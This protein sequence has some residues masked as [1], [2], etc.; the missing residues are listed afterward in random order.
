MINLFYHYYK[1]ENVNR[2][3]ELLKCYL[4]NCNLP[5]IDNIYVLQQEDTLLHTKCKLIKINNRPTYIDFFKIINEIA[6]SNDINIICNTDIYFDSTLT[7]LN[8]Y[9]FK[10]HVLC[11]EKY[12]VLPNNTIKF[13]NQYDSQDTWI[14]K[15]KIKEIQE[16]NFT[17]GIPGCDNKLAFLFDKHG[18][19]SINPSL[20][21]KTYHLHNVLY[22]TY[23]K[24]INKLRLPPPYK[25]LTPTK[26]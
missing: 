16:C 19:K 10:N 1:C 20:T 4:N 5:Y 17:Q 15:G 13:N 23:L 3:D 2:Q 14:F 9:D 6:S 25:Y 26:L 7:L 21:I 22:R 11:L 24:D 12:N 8:N 18:Y